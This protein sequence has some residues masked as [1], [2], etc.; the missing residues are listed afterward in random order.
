MN[1]YCSHIFQRALDCEPLGQLEKNSIN[2]HI[3]AMLFE[4]REYSRR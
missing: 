2:H 1:N 3:A 4:L